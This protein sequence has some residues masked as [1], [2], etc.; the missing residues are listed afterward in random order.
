MGAANEVDG[1]ARCVSVL[2]GSA[3]TTDKFA[4]STAVEDTGKDEKF[5]GKLAGSYHSRLLETTSY[6]CFLSDT[7]HSIHRLDLYSM[8]GMF[9]NGG[10]S[11]PSF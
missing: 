8:S 2:E 7:L 5:N 4:K 1:H 3:E 11:K 10:R 6:L 9:V